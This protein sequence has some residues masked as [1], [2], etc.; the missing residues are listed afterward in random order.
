MAAKARDWKAF[1]GAHKHRG[2]M[3]PVVF[4]PRGR[5][6]PPEYDQSTGAS[7]NYSD[8]LIESLLKLKVV[9]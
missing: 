4:D 7:K 8:A 1:A 2:A 3:P 9:L 5:L 6:S